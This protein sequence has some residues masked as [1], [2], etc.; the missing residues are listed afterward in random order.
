MQTW[1]RAA[2][3]SLS[4]GTEKGTHT[5]FVKKARSQLI[6]EGNFM[7]ARAL[8]ILVCGAINEPRLPADGSIRNQ[9]F[10]FRCDQSYGELPRSSAESTRSRISKF[11]LMRD[12]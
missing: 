10:C 1:K 9:F 11:L 6:N 4:S 5:D 12:T 7:A 8:D 3:H 2:G